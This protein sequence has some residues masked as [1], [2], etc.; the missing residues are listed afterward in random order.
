MNKFFTT[1]AAAIFAGAMLTGCNS[2]PAKPLTYQELKDSQPPAITTFGEPKVDTVISKTNNLQ[3]SINQQLGKYAK[4]IDSKKEY[5]DL[6]LEFANAKEE[7]IPKI[8]TEKFNLTAELVNKVN[9]MRK[10]GEIKALQGQVTD[11]AKSATDLSKN[12]T[13]SGIGFGA[14]ATKAANRA[15]ALNAV[16]SNLDY[17]KKELDFLYNRYELLINVAKNLKK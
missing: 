14:E 1:T 3:S 5:K 7:E 11:I 10:I 6:I 16:K 2:T 8:V 4:E 13:S 17:S 15:K 12:A 9:P